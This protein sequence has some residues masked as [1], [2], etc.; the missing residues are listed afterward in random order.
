MPNSARLPTSEDR[1]GIPSILDARHDSR[2]TPSLPELSPG[3][4][5][6]DPRSA[7]SSGYTTPLPPTPMTAA[8]GPAA[9][10][11]M[12]SES[13]TGTVKKMGGPLE[14]GQHTH[15]NSYD[16][17]LTNGHV[18]GSNG[19]YF[20]GSSNWYGDLAGGPGMAISGRA[21][22]GNKPN[23][24]ERSVSAAGHYSNAVPQRMAS[25]SVSRS[26]SQ[27]R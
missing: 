18:G 5:V 2:Y 19:A 12:N 24:I 7:Y 22:N 11:T 10:A 13:N 8:L 9:Q 1:Y 16:N 15:Q 21:V 14:A 23:P 25:R 6:G 26:A 20:G 3:A 17:S 4:P 27:R